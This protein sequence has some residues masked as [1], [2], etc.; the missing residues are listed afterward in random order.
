VGPSGAGKSSALSLLLRLYDPSDGRVRLANAHEFIMRLPEGYETILGERGPREVDEALRRR[1]RGRTTVIVAHDLSS[2]EHA[3][4]IL[5]L[6]AGE[7]VERGTHAQLMEQDGTY[8]T[9][10]RLQSPE[11]PGERQQPRRSWAARLRWS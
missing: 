11:R 6:E 10:Y 8:A 4:Q 1:G 7:S 2:V 3:D 5:Y 9:V